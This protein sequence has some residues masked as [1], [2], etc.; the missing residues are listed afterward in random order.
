MGLVWPSGP[1]ESSEEQG[2]VKSSAMRE[3][4]GL[5]HSSLE[6]R[7]AVAGLLEDF[8]CLMMMRVMMITAT[9]Y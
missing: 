3:H 6:S 5:G 7:P 8:Y 9:M 4:Q 1:W 2:A